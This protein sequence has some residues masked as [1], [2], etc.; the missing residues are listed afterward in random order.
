[1]TARDSARYITKT[2]STFV[3]FLALRDRG[4]LPLR[5]IRRLT[6]ST[7]AGAWHQAPEGRRICTRPGDVL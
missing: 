4:E 5:S 1:M 7:T 6:I 3:L 2:R